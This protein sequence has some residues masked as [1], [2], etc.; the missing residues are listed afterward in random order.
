MGSVINWFVGSLVFLVLTIGFAGYMGV[1]L[2]SDSTS[3]TGMTNSSGSFS[4]SD[5]IGFASGFR[6]AWNEAP[7]LL[8]VLLFVPLL[9]VGITSYLIAIRGA[10]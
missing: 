1:D 9:I 3:Y 10:N 6:L 5:T 7:A 2:G 8:S 4:A